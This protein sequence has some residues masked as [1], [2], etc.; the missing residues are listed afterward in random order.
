[1]PEAA[2]ILGIL[3]RRFRKET[4][5]LL[6]S[7]RAETGAIKMQCW[8]GLWRQKNSAIL[9]FQLIVMDKTIFWLWSRWWMSIFE[10]IGAE[11]VYNH[12][13]YRL[14]SAKVLYELAKFGEVNLFLRR[15]DFAGRIQK[16]KRILRTA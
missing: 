6:E 15:N 10:C 8:R 13:D 7:V 4:I 16:H 12:A 2:I 9:R 14:I 1:M 3:S 5:I 11:V